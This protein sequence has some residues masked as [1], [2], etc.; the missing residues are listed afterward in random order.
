MH[1]LNVVAS[2]VLMTF[3]RPGRLRH[4]FDHERIRSHLRYLRL[5]FKIG[6]SWSHRNTTSSFE[7]RNYS[8]YEDY[9]EHQKDKRDRTDLDQYD[10][11]YRRTLR[12]RLEQLDLQLGGMT[13]LCL[14]V[15]P[16]IGDNHHRSE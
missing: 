5:H 11:D 4:L 2:E 14:A 1:F 9:L 16:T 12:G 13:V 8:S 3:R 15:R 7:K 10:A 6:D